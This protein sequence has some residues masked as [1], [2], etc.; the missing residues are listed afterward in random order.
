M[1]GASTTATVTQFNNFTVGQKHESMIIFRRSIS[2][3]LSF[4]QL[5]F[6]PLLITMTRQTV[7]ETKLRKILELN[8]KLKNQL[9]IPRIPVSEASRS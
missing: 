8:D 6:F 5:F 9:D 7:S 2:F 3:L 1:I 4:L